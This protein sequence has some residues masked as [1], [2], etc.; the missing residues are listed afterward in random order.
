MEIKLDKV[1]KKYK[2]KKAVKELDFEFT[3]GIWGLLGPNGAGK[4]TLIRML[5]TNII[6]IM[7]LSGVYRYFKRNR[8]KNF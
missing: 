7:G 4:T 2:N 3:E 6:I 1:S 8:Q 5:T